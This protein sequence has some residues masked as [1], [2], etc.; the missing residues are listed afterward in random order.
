MFVIYKFILYKQ[1][2]GGSSTNIY[3]KV[4]ID[5]VTITYNETNN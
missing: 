4:A 5:I 2:V 3:F 1:V